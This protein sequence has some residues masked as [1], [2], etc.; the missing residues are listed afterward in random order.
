[1]RYRTG[2]TF[3]R[4]RYSLAQESNI[5]GAPWRRPFISALLCTVY[6]YLVKPSKYPLGRGGSKNVSKRNL[7]AFHGFI[8]F[9]R[10]QSLFD[11]YSR[12]SVPITERH[13]A[14]PQL[15]SGGPRCSCVSPVMLYCQQVRVDLQ[16]TRLPRQKQA[17]IHPSRLGLLSVTIEQP[18]LGV[19]EANL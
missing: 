11:V 15:L 5:P 10:L 16:E 9:P 18:C 3:A 17:Q 4:E 19:M 1:M 2:K 6:S 14:G 13:D 8:V 7:W 12:S